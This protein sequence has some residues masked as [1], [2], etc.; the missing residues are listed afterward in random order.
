MFASCSV[1]RTVRI[2]DTREARHTSAI[3]VVAHDSDVNV[4][5]WS[6]LA[7]HLLASGGDDGFFKVWDLRNFQ[8]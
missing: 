4:I 5:S 7:N 1:D 2:W 6:R 3:S 8:T